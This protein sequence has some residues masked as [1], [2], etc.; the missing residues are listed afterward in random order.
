MSFKETASAE[1][2]SRALVARYESLDL[3]LHIEGEVSRYKLERPLGV[4]ASRH[5]TRG[6]QDPGAYVDNDVD[7][8]YA[9]AQ[10]LI[11]VGLLETFEQIEVGKRVTRLRSTRAGRMYWLAVHGLS[12]AFLDDGTFVLRGDLGRADLVVDI[13]RILHAVGSPLPADETAYLVATTLRDPEHR[14][15]SSMG[16]KLRR[17]WQA[18]PG[19]TY[20]NVLKNAHY[21]RTGHRRTV[22]RLGINR[23]GLDAA[24]AAG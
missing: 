10:V 1:L 8:L 2:F 9:D 4:L 21:A 5:A 13:A 20:A 18:K 3:D 23:A 15:D 7:I 19:G 17:A 11:D 24:L 16:G 22:L 6:P 14:T 12:G